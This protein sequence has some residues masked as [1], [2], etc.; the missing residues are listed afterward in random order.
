MSD[1]VPPIQFA[2]NGSARLAYQMWGDGPATIVG[3]P[4]TAQSI[5]L[6][7][8]RPEI[9][10]MFDRFGHMGRYLHFDKRG[11]GA[12]ARRTHVNGIDERVRIDQRELNESNR[13]YIATEHLNAGQRY[14]V[15]VQR[16]SGSLCADA[17]FI[18]HLGY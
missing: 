12:S 4:P 6:A 1:E 16:S 11:T 18:R 13:A 5:E 2:N 9:R 15:S 14:Y 7:W 3:I 17:V 8:E 10:Y